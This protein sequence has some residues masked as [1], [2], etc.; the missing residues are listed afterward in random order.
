MPSRKYHWTTTNTE[1]QRK[2][3]Y[4]IHSADEWDIRFSLLKAMPNMRQRHKSCGIY[5]NQYGNEA[6]HKEFGSRFYPNHYRS[7][8]G[9]NIGVIRDQMLQGAQKGWFG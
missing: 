6:S 9:N 3:V 1:I 7:I 4:N 8:P 2:V 5:K